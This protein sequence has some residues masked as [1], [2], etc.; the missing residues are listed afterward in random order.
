MQK[1]II[2]L[3]KKGLQKLGEVLYP[4]RCPF[5][6]KMIPEGICDSCRNILEEVSEPCCRKCGKPIRNE[7]KEYCTDCEKRKPPFEEGR[8]VWLHKEPVN[9]A[10][11]RF[12]YQNQRYYGNL[13]ADCLFEKFSGE[14]KRWQIEAI[15]PV[16]L[17]WKKQHRR[18]YNQAEILGARLSRLSGIPLRLDLVFRTG[19]TIPLKQLN[20]TE[21]RKM[22]QNAF[23]VSEEAARCRNVLLIDDIYTSGATIGTIA[24][25]MK[26]KGVSKV[27]FFTISI[28]QGF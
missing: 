20:P 24:R 7:Q 13:F 3:I 18:G 11:Y 27:Y 6:G 26:Q 14:L 15:V 12:K 25:K 10:I 8:S 28:G 5:C 19:Y 9:Q 17:H 21:R 1:R 22:L 23:Y 16:P 4:Y 2:N